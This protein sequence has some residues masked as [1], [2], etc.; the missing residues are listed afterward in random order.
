MSNVRVLLPSHRRPMRRTRSS[1]PLRL[2]LVA[3][4]LV[5]GL[6]AR[7]HFG[8]TPRIDPVSSS[9]GR[10]LSIPAKPDTA[11]FLQTD[12]RWADDRI[13]GSEQPIAAVGCTICT[14]CT[15]CSI[16]MAASRLGVEITPKNLNAR[17]IHAKGYTDR[18]WVI[19]REGETAS[20]KRIA[21]RVSNRLTHADIDDALEAGR[22]LVAKFF[23]PNGVQHRASSDSRARS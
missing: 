3:A 1:G 7:H 2:P 9:G 15:I 19:W 10:S 18:G 16:A 22:V 20:D 23:L 12:P 21:V 14:I 8:R 11:H 13:G 6:A 5:A 17:L 4:V